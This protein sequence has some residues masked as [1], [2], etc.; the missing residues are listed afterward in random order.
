MIINIRNTSCDNPSFSQCPCHCSCSSAGSAGDSPL[1]EH[2]AEGDNRLALV[3]ERLPFTQKGTEVR[4][5]R[6]G[7]TPDGYIP[8]ARPD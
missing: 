5:G 2:H 8:G 6:D 4:W 3:R 7:Q 1:Q